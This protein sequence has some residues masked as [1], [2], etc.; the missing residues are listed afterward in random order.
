MGGGW[1]AGEDGPHIHHSEHQVGEGQTASAWSPSS[2]AGGDK[3]YSLCQPFLGRGAR[4]ARGCGGLRV[5]DTGRWL[6][7][8]LGRAR[9]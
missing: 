8:F 5:R 9:S 2:L 4:R 7:R 6:L 3:P 1:P